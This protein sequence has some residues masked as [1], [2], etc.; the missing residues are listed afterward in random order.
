MKNKNCKIGILIIATILLIS[1]TASAQIVVNNAE[2]NKNQSNFSIEYSLYFTEEDFIFGKTLEFDTISLKDSGHIS[3]IGK[4]YLPM[5]KL[6]IALP[7]DMLATSIRI[8]DSSQKYLP[9]L[10]SVLP[11][12]EPQPF[13]KI[14]DYKNIVHSDDP[15]YLNSEPYPSDIIE[16]TGQTDLAGQAI[17]EINIY[18]VQ[19]I[20]N[21]MR[22]KILTSIDFVIEGVDGYVCGDYLSRSISIEEKESYMETIKD[23]VLNPE[24]VVLSHSESNIQPLDLDPGDY[25]YVIIT[26]SDWEDDFLPLANWKTKKGIPANIMT[27]EWIYSEYSGSNKQKIREFV[28]DAHT[29]WGTTYFLLGGDTGTIPYHTVSYAGSN[30]PTDTYYADYDDDWFCEV[31]V[32]RASVYQTGSGAGGIDKFIDKSLDYE[33]SP[34]ST[35]FAKRIALLGFDLNSAT[36]GEDCKEDI[37]EEYIPAGWSVTKVYDS[38]SGNHETEVV[39]TL[40]NGQNLINHIDHCNQNYMGMG[41]VNH[42]WG[43]YSSD[44]DDLSNGNKQSTFYSIGCYACAYDYDNCIA[45]HFVRDTNGGGVAFVGNSRYGWFYS[46][47]DDQASLRYDRYFFKS[48]FTENHYKLGNAF[49]DHKT[50][51]YASMDDDSYNKFI[52]QELTL[53]GDPELPIWKENPKSFTV[54]HP[55]ALPIGTSSF[56]VHVETSGGENV[57]QAK[58]CLWKDDEV[59]LISS[60]S[61]SGDVTLYPSPETIGEMYV[62]VTKQNFKP[63]EGDAEVQEFIN[64]P[65]YMPNTPYPENNAEDIEIETTIT[66]QGGDPNPGDSVVYDVYFGTEFPLEKVSDDQPQKS[67]DPGPLEF[68]KTYYWQI[69][70]MD[71]HGSSTEGPNWHFT[72]MNEPNEP[73]EI[74]DEN[75]SHGSANI[76][77]T[78]KSINVHIMDLEGDKI[79]WNIETSPDIGSSSGTDEGNGTKSCSITGLSYDTTYTWYVN[80]SDLGSNVWTSETFTF[81]TEPEPSAEPDLLC[82]GNLIWNNVNAGEKVIGSFTIENIG[83]IGSE[84]DWQITEWPDTWGEWTFSPKDGENLRPEDG[85]ITINVEVIAPDQTNSEFNGEIKI[86]NLENPTDYETMQVTLKTPRDKTHINSLFMRILNEMPDLYLL[87]KYVFTLLGLH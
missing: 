38:D 31:H 74:S 51:A 49:S 65:P 7:Q 17:A 22:L 58:V 36:P 21:Q 33:K 44:I 63:Y 84:L 81:S 8:V 28:M 69:I 87:I 19:Y 13:S 26:K 55:N 64:D 56:T 32:G 9:G 70:S 59:Y 78:L 6:L 77:V 71:N 53:L 42:G 68:G 12:Q 86:Q 85:T 73:P 46:G 35:N 67:Y 5:K 47:D 54:S 20:P 3:E 60:T 66:W 1:S 15:I 29:N 37:E 62:T 18:P 52:F 24:D 75:P 83:D 14:N 76:K 57:N 50:D 45:E 10:F 72:T 39:T 23:L 25:D 4:P 79:N 41:H 43:L 11:A 61:Y 27:T 82:N 30:I 40:N 34:P 16:L 80:A 48:L 2:K